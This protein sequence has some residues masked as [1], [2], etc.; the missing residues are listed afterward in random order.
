M[1][2][3]LI[4]PEL[5]PF[6]MIIEYSGGLVLTGFGFLTLFRLPVSA[7]DDTGTL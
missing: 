2:S 1:D 7:G 5:A 6:D 3:P 4:K